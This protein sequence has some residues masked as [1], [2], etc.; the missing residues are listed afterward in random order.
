MPLFR[1]AVDRL[2]DLL[3]RDGKVIYRAVLNARVAP[4]T[5]PLLDKIVADDEDGETL[6]ISLIPWKQAERPPIAIYRG[7]SSTCRI[8]GPWQVSGSHWFPIGGLILTPGVT[9]H[10]DPFDALALHEKMQ[11]AIEDTILAWARDHDLYA[12]SPVPETINRRLADRAA[13]A[14]IAAWASAEQA[15]DS[16]PDHDAQEPHA[17][18]SDEAANTLCNACRKGLPHD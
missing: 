6:R 12:L 3:R 8:D 14:M 18:C 16:E 11:Q 2:S 4:Y 13:K 7:D 15:P 1:K 5:V 10:L 17:C 9:A